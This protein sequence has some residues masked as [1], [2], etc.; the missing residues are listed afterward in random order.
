MLSLYI[1]FSL[2]VCEDQSSAPPGLHSLPSW[3]LLEVS[4]H[5]SKGRY[6]YGVGTGTGMVEGE[7]QPV[8]GRSRLTLLLR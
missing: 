2:A 5:M 4:I 6:R 1:T 3:T 8:Q 7:V